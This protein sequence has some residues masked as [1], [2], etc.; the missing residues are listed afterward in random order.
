MYDL[1]V[2]IPRDPWA[3]LNRTYGPKCGHIARLSEHGCIEVDLREPAYEHL[4]L[5]AKVRTAGP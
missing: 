4:R 5:P 2:Q 1:E 3:L